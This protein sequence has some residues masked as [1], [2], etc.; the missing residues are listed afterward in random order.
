MLARRRALGDETRREASQSVCGLILD[1]VEFNGCE[2][3]L[4]YSPATDDYEIDPRAL[5]ELDEALFA[6]RKVLL[7]RVPEDGDRLE[8]F[9]LPD[10]SASLS[11]ADYYSLSHDH[12]PLEI[13]RFN[14]PEPI[15]GRCEEAEPESLDLVFVPGVAFDPMGYRVGFGSGFYDRLL[16]DLPGSAVTVG[17]CYDFQLIDRCPRESHDRPVDWVINESEALDSRS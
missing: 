14:V 6:S 11:L 2:S 12:A 4:F 16:A 15:P 13:G 10:P 1:S 5:F 9:E 17:L 8:L 3:V 7:P